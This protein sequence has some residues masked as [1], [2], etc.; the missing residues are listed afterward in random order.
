MDFSITRVD[1]FDADIDLV[2]PFGIAT[3]AQVVANNLFV[4]IELACGA[5]GWGEAAPFPAVNGETRDH[6]R[7][8]V[9]SVAWIGRDARSWRALSAEIAPLCG[10]AR[11]ALE[12]ALLDAACQAYGMPMWTFFGGSS[13]SLETDVTITTGTARDA[14]LAAARLAG[15]GVRTLKI[16]V[17]GRAIA[18]D[19]SRIAAIV[20]AAPGC[21]LLLD[22]NAAIADARSALILLDG[23]RDRGGDVILFE[24]PLGKHDLKGMAELVRDG[25]CPIA[26]DEAIQ[27]PADVAR[28]AI[29]RAA[30]VVN[31]KATKSGLIGA[32]D[33]AIAAK[34]HGM[35]L[36][37]G[38]MVETP[39]A[40]TAS[41]CLAAGMGGFSYVDLDTD[42]WMRDPPVIGG[43][44]AR[45]PALDLAGIAAGHG[46]RPRLYG[47]A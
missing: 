32:M 7:S 1:R 10:S 9:D 22:A 31:L 27:S 33:M 28:I 20:A 29:A 44:V 42:R 37:I 6:A 12:T 39:L 41:A 36:M 43:F 30:N 21:R 40:L 25:R 11:C 47:A 17:G 14:A 4:R 19:L 34:A 38:A 3:G 13:T 5:E 2:E 18:D 46:V 8:A 24:Q 35:G 15:E 45:G 23:V 26:V 16:K